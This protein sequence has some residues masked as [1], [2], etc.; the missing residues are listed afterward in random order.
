MGMEKAKYKSKVSKYLEE[1][2]RIKEGYDNAKISIVDEYEVRKMV[3]EDVEQRYKKI[4][5]AF[6]RG[7]AEESLY[8]KAQEDYVRAEEILK[9]TKKSLDEIEVYMNGRLD[10]VITKLNKLKRKYYEEINSE[11]KKLKYQLMKAKYDFLLTVTQIHGVYKK[12]SKEEYQLQKL[13]EDLGLED[14]S[15]SDILDAYQLLSTAIISDDGA[16]ITKKE[17]YDALHSGKIPSDLEEEITE[18]RNQGYIT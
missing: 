15:E 5:E 11:K 3:F 10:V 2:T 14:G 13:N 1:A 8:K 17:I 16:A 12:L 6:S 7:E 9:E 4:H 18:A